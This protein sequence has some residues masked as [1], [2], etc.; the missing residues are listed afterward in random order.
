MAAKDLA[1]RLA[2]LAPKAPIPG[3][4]DDEDVEVDQIASRGPAAL[5]GQRDVATRLAELF[6]KIVADAS[7]LTVPG[8]PCQED[9]AAW[10]DHGRVREPDRLGQFGRVDKE[11]AH[12]R[13]YRPVHSGRC[14]LL[15][16]S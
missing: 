10:F 2:Q 6:Q 15:N 1:I 4:V 14:P 11:V 8:L 9:H 13:R 3:N 12:R 5:Q 7:V 16:A